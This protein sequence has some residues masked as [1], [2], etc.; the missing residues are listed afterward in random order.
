[1]L[2]MRSSLP[3]LFKAK[4]FF[5]KCGKL[6]SGVST[7]CFRFPYSSQAKN[8]WLLQNPN[9]DETASVYY[10]F[11]ICEMGYVSPLHLNITSLVSY[12]IF[13]TAGGMHDKRK[14]VTNNNS[15]IV[16]SKTLGILWL[17]C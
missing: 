16:K 8:S 15:T 10:V 17:E 14:I 5:P 7:F 9:I 1:M 3:V 4:R 6:H 11:I 13:E 12:I 2:E